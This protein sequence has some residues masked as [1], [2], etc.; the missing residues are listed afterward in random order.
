[1]GTQSNTDALRQTC[2]KAKAANSFSKSILQHGMAVSHCS[3]QPKLRCGQEYCTKKWQK[4]I[5]AS[6]AASRNKLRWT[7]AGNYGCFWCFRELPM[8]KPVSCIILV[9]GSRLEITMPHCRL[10]WHVCWHLKRLRT[11][12]HFDHRSCDQQSRKSQTPSSF[13]ACATL[14]LCCVIALGQEGPP[15]ELQNHSHWKTA[16]AWHL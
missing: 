16:L 10:A 14:I 9:L 5:T 4:T 12:D 6:D 1:M 8:P 11:F 7:C 13:P 3:A 15:R 2:D